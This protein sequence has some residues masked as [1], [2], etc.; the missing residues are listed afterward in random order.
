MKEIRFLYNEVFSTEDLLSVWILTLSRIYSDLIIVNKNMLRL[1]DQENYCESEMIYFS[2]LAASH[3]REALKFI[4]S[5]SEELEIDD[6]ISKLDEDL[7]NKY[8]TLISSVKSSPSSNE[9]PSKCFKNS[10]VGRYLK[11]IR[12]N[13]FHY[14][15]K[16][17]TMTRVHKALSILGN[18]PTRIVLP[19]DIFGNVDFVFADEIAVFLSY[20][21]IDSEEL[22]SFTKK[23][24][25]YIICLLDFI[26][27]VNAIYFESY[28]GKLCIEEYD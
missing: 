9:E 26:Q 28:E 25:V 11:P 19:D 17:D 5:F 7:I 2:K 1:L 24:L 12:D 18:H 23:L 20:G 6:F 15:N 3:Y 27:A 8:I 13:F 16:K 22:T 21:S 4:G 10:F 14:Y